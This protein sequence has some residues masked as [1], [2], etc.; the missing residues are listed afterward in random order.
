MGPDGVVV[1][2]GDGDSVV[3]S[4]DG[5]GGGVLAGGVL[6]WVFSG[7]GEGAL[8]AQAERLCGYLDGD[9]GEPSA[10]DVG[11]S[12]ASR[13]V[14]ERRA[15]VL[16]GDR[17]GLLGGLGAFAGGESGV[18]VVEGGVVGVSGLVGG[19]FVY[20]SGFSACGYGS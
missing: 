9:T 5:S 1:A 2:D 13:S 18:G 17:E 7:K 20:G 11:Y 16:G 14:F 12:L 8:R 3:L 10:I 19:V 15:V 6:P 4:E